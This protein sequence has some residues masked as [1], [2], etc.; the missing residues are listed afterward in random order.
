MLQED[1]CTSILRGFKRN[2]L[3]SFA[4][5]LNLKIIPSNGNGPFVTNGLYL[6]YERKDSN[7]CKTTTEIFKRYS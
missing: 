7:C 6:K 5:T 3:Q 1:G 4:K 2:E